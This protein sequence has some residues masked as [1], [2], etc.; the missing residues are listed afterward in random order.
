MSESSRRGTLKIF[1]GYAAGVG[2]TYQMLDEA[3]KLKNEGVDVIVGYF[4]PHGRKDTIT[5]SE[6]LEIVP[7]RKVEY[8]GAVFG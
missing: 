6:G 7:R 8:R 3:H 4:E 1:L 2:K 5:K